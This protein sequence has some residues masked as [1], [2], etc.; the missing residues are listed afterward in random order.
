MPPEIELLNKLGAGAEIL[1]RGASAWSAAMVAYVLESLKRLEGAYT[2]PPGHRT[3]KPQQVPK[4]VWWKTFV[5]AARDT[6]LM[7]PAI[8]RI[9]RNQVAPS[10]VAVVRDGEVDRIVRLRRDTLAAMSK[11]SRPFEFPLSSTVFWREWKAF[12]RLAGLPVELRVCPI[13]PPAEERPILEPTEV[14]P[15]TD[16]P[17]TVGEFFERFYF[18]LRL[19]GKSERTVTL[20][21]YSIKTF[22]R[23][24]GRPALLTDFE[25]LT[26]ANYL[27]HLG[28]THQP[29][30][31]EK[32]RCQ[33]LAMWRLANEYHFVKLPP[34]VRKTPL[35]RRDPVSWTAS[36]LQRLFA[37][38][39][40]EKGDYAGIPAGK[41]WTAL[42]MVV[43]DTGERIDAVLSL[44]WEDFDLDGRWVRIKAEYR[45]GKTSDKTHR[46]HQDTVD[47]L[48]AIR[49]PTHEKA[50]PWPY[51]KHYLWDVYGLILSTAHLPNDRLRKFHCLR[52]SVASHFEAAGGNA[53]AL[54]DHTS[55]AITEKSYLDPRIVPRQQASEMLFRPY[56]NT[57]TG[58][59]QQS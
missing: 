47:A 13:H 39:R 36:E 33:L 15:A 11:R 22:S 37:A 43:W 10:G 57:Q 18:P 26:V 44:R 14:K 51:C 12:C 19:R 27:A 16:A 20:Y 34:N 48:Q 23:W 56:T 58:K 3:R 9:R 52:R 41:W 42:L 53:T 1:E 46:L 17:E 6:G 55:R 2:L 8:C 5:L 50:L 49:N 28:K 32:E 38:A 21:Q 24:L 35:P 40:R 29:H 54:L 45:K 25:D 30:S 7:R 4:A 59:D 31:I